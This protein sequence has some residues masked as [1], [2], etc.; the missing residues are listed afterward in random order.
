M[1]ETSRSIVRNGVA[2]FF[3]G[4]T[5]DPTF[6]AYRDGPLMQ[7]G[8]STVRAYQP[9]ELPDFDYVLGQQPGRGMGT[10]M[11]LELNETRDAPLTITQLPGSRGQR[12]LVYPVQC[13]LFGR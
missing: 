6:K 1:A 3:G 8:L 5:F 12:K 2:Q 11:I 13:H 7:Y 10:V 9:K 4:T